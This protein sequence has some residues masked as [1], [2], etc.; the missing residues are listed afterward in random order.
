MAQ[1]EIKVYGY[2]WIMLSAYML[3]VAVN[4]ML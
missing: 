1:E 3:I 2:R 4:Q